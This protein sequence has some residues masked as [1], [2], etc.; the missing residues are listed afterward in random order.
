MSSAYNTFYEMSYIPCN[1]PN[2]NAALEAG[3]AQVNVDGVSVM[4]GIKV[5]DKCYTGGYTT[6]AGG[7]VPGHNQ[8]FHV[9]GFNPSR[10]S[11]T[12]NVVAS[13]A[14]VAR[15]TRANYL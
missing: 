14:H 8:L 7:Y 2:M 12:R 15:S 6:K 4:G 3:T 5:N 1:H 11:A 10:Y 9:G 13:N